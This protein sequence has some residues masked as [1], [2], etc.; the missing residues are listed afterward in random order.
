MRITGSRLLDNFKKR[1]A[2]SQKALASW[3]RHMTEHE[4]R[5]FAELRN[6][7]SSVDVV[8]GWMIFDIGGNKYRLITTVDIQQQHC[9]IEA[10]LTHENYDRRRWMKQISVREPRLSGWGPYEDPSTVHPI[11]AESDYNAALA[12]VTQLGKWGASD[13]NH[14]QNRLLG[15]IFDALYAYE[16]VHYPLP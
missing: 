15:M 5:N 16:K 4:C 1:H 3:T 6:V 8:G 9:H 13:S 7:F 2:K 10:V 14:P 11:R 12:V